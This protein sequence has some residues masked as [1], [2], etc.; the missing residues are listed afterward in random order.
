MRQIALTALAALFLSATAFAQVGP[1]PGPPPHRGFA[2][3]G[4]FGPGVP[5][6]NPWKV[7]TGAPYSAKMAEQSVQTLANGVTITH[8]TTGIVARDNSG[9]TYVEQ[10]FTGGPFG[11]QNG[12]KTVIFLTDPVAGYAYTLYPDKNLAIQRPFKAPSAGSFANR[13][14]HTHAND[15]NVNVQKSTSGNIETTTINRTIPANTMGNSSTLTS[16]STVQYSTSLQIV[17]SSTRSDPRFGNSTYTLSNIVPG[18]PAN[19]SFSVPNGYTIQTEPAHG[20]RGPN[21]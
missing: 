16:T 14:N 18:D 13:P 9:R 1:P 21:Q 6:M 17:V 19:I 5:G 8:S 10:T 4:P 7:V 11:S 12:S 3:G 20:H 15:P 2:R